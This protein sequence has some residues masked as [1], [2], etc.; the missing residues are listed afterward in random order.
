MTTNEPYMKKKISTLLI[1]SA[2]ALLLLV[3]SPMFFS[4]PLLQP[5]Q[6]TSI[7]NIIQTKNPVKLGTSCS[8]ANATLT[9]EANGNGGTLTNGT[10]QI[11]DSSSGKILWSGDLYRA[12]SQGDVLLVYSVVGSVPVCGIGSG[13]VLQIQTRCERNIIG[14]S[15]DGT[16]SGLAPAQVDCESSTRDTTTAQQPSSS[17][18]MTAGT[19]TTT[20][21]SDGDRDGIP[22]SSDRC[23]HNSNHRCFKEGDTSTTTQQQSSSTSMGGNQTR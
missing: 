10:F 9:F 2:I 15:T 20:Q 21:D 17:T 18:P 7:P 3:S 14:L 4:N 16:D 5:V 22:D 1:F 19:T 6:A 12:N 11:S 8:D 23:I 13:D